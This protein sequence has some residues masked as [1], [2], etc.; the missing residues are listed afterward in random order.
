MRTPNKESGESVRPQDTPEQET[1]TSQTTEGRVLMVQTPA[2]PSSPKDRRKRKTPWWEKT[3][4]IIALGLLFVNWYQGCQTKK[5]A[6]A[7]KS[8][9]NTGDRTLKI[10]ERAW[11]TI[12]SGGPVTYTTGKIIPAP[13]SNNQYR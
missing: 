2:N 12:T 11:I 6:E 10:D 1:P 13:V 3:A 7:A 8:A 4:V 9:A 5:A